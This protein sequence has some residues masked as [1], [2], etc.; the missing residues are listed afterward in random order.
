MKKS[1]AKRVVSI[2]LVLSGLFTAS[3]GIWN[4]FPPFNES[5]SP[6]HAIGSSIFLAICAIHIWLNWKILVRYFE[7]LGWWWIVVLSGLLS[8]ILIITI[9]ILRSV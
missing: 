2:S 6:G 9:P 3:T 1:A 7:G 5:F 8:V 4:F